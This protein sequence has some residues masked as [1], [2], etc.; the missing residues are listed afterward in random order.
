MKVWLVWT[1]EYSDATV[2]GVF[3]TEELA[4]E[5]CQMYPDGYTG[6]AYEVDSELPRVRAGIRLW[7]V[8]MEVDGTV[9]SVRHIDIAKGKPSTVNRYPSYTVTGPVERLLIQCDARD[10]DHAIKIAADVRA[11]FLALPELEAH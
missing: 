6:D 10:Q 5:A 7:N 3:S 11:K 9:V 4:K 8:L 1:G 2:E